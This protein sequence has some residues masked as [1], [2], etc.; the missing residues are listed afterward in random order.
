SLREFA[1]RVARELPATVSGI[2][3]AGD[4]DR[5][6][7]RVSLCGGAGDSLLDHPEVRGSD[8]YVTSD[9][10]HHPA[11]ESLEQSVASAGPALIDVSH[12]ASESLWL[13]D[14]AE[15]LSAEL[16]GV[17]FRVSVLRTDPWTFSVGA[18]N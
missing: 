8:L 4:P 2:R 6:I 14:A 10:R 7:S 13:R 15:E 5:V 1:D 3:V 18:T 17:E 11:Q 12:W 9:L 16:P